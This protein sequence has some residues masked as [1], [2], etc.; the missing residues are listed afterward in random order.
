MSQCFE[1]AR[2][3]LRVEMMAFRLSASLLSS[4]LKSILSL[5]I[6]VE[7]WSSG[8]SYA[9][10]DGIRHDGMRLL[11]FAC[12]YS[13]SCP[14]LSFHFSIISFNSYFVIREIFYS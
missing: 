11:G 10:D 3:G 9:A 2:W 8:V 13:S 1:L 7:T 12:V 4:L 5:L 6:W 14:V